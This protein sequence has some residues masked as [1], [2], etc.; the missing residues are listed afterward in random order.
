VRTP[1]TSPHLHATPGN[2]IQLEIVEQTL[3]DWHRRYRLR[4]V[5]FDP[6][7]MESMAQRLS[8]SGVP[9][10][11]FPQTVPNLTAATTNLFDLIQSRRIALYPDPAM[12]LAASRIILHES[13][14]GW[15][16]DKL[17]QNHK[18]DVVVALEMALYAAVQGQ[19]EYFYDRSYAAFQPNAV[20][21]DAPPPKANPV[22]E[23]DQRLND[24]YQHIDNA[25]RWGMIR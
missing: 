14:R 22:P 12:R 25:I 1:R 13:A 15:R 17:K 19:N 7:Q 18:I 4:K 23:A 24:F 2:P 16:L 11:R 5:L 8:A 6:M 9:I 20:D 3:L 10:E 21:L